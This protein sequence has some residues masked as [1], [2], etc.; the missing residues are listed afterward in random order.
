MSSTVARYIVESLRLAGTETFF[1]VPG[2]HN[3][4]LWAAMEQSGARYVGF[5]HEQAAAHA[6]DGYGRASGRPGAV[7]LP[8]GPGALG[9]L[10]ALAE[11]LVSSSPVVAIAST[12]PSRLVGKG[13]GHLHEAKDPLP[14]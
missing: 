7:F 8:S 2:L 1:G 4:G 5:R 9:A 13:K 12:I 3:L 11:A 10:P 14:A 6:A